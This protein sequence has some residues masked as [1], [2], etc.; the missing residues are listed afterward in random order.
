MTNLSHVYRETGDIMAELT[1]GGPYVQVAAICTTQLIEQTGQLS[2]IRIQDR[3]QLAGP[4]DQMQPTPLNSLAIVISLKSGEMRGKG[5]LKVTPVTP[6]GKLLA[7]AA[8]QTLFEGD[9]RGI[10]LALPLAVVAE[11]EGLYWFEVTV[12]E[13][14]LTRIPLRVM[15]QKLQPAQMGTGPFSQAD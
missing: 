9:E 10:I 4:T 13:V 5:E 11:E 1:F 12:D 8:F 6:A 3:V 14:L 7:P 2:V 15:Y